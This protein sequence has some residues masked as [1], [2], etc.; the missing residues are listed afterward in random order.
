MSYALVN[1]KNGFK[2][3]VGYEG[4]E[5]II[6]AKSAWEILR[7]LLREIFSDKKKD[8]HDLLGPLTTGCIHWLNLRTGD[9]Y[10]TPVANPWLMSGSSTWT[11][12]GGKVHVS[13]FAQTDYVRLPSI[14]TAR[15]FSM[16]RR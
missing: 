7:F 6:L 16:S 11:I 4:D 1:E 13:E 2:I 3:Y 14:P 5:T 12:N 9:V 15:Y 8:T 10:I